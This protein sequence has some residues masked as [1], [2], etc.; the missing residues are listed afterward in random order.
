MRGARRWGAVL[1][2]VLLAHGLVGGWLASHRALFADRSET[3]PVEVALLQPQPIAREAAPI[4]HAPAVAAARTPRRPADAREALQALDANAPTTAPALAAP[5]AAPSSADTRQST[6]SAHGQTGKHGDTPESRNGAK[7][8]VPPSGEFHYD[9]FYN[10]VQNAPGTIHWA[11]NAERYEILVSLPLPFVG[12][13]TYASRGRIDAFGLSPERYIEQRGRRPEEVTTF[14]RAA[15]RIAFTRT[16]ATLP[17]P[18]GAQDRFSMIMQLASLVRGEPNA[19][20]PG[21]TRNFYV[22][23]NDSGEFWPIETIGDERVRAAQGVVNAR[24]FMRLPRY[25]GD[26]RRIDIWLAPELGWLPARIRQTEPN[27]T[28]IELVW[29][30]LI[31]SSGAENAAE[32][33]TLEQPAGVAP[34]PAPI[35]EEP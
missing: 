32:Q 26:A 15:G 17:L 34:A 12:T 19:Y 4:A 9:T 11:S 7:F 29:Q 30:A 20:M 28:Q 13:F 21:V 10:G 25:A 27:G 1:A 14:D 35:R 31:V 33:M 5:R 23:D 16:S 8:S 6:E 2:A 22:A 3:L 24:H 18:N